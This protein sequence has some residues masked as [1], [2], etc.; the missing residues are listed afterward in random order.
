MVILLM[1]VLILRRKKSLC[2][3]GVI[4]DSKLTFETHLREIVSKAVKS[5]GVMRRAENY[6]IN[7][8]C[9]RAVSM[10]IFWPT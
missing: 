7:H 3:L 2:S 1:V 10:R 6:L 4:L 8:V 5:L 9:S